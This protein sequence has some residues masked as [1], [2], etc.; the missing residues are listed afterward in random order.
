MSSYFIHC[1]RNHTSTCLAKN[2]A[3]IQQQGALIKERIGAMN[4]FGTL[5]GAVL[6][7]GVISYVAFNVSLTF[8]ILINLIS[9]ENPTLITGANSFLVTLLDNN[10]ITC[11]S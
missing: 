8:S 10:P 7:L 1:A 4:L 5:G 6:A 2:T 3:S 11:H 9:N